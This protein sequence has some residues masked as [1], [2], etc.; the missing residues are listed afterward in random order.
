MSVVG[1]DLGN[2]NAVVAVARNRGV[3]VI[4]N[5]VSNRMTPSLVSFGPKSRYLGEAAK[6]QE[7]SNFRNTVASLKRLLGRSLAEV[8]EAERRH[9][10]CELT[11]K[12]SEVAVR[13]EYRGAECVFSATELLA[14]FLGKLKDITQAEVKNAAMD[15][16]VAVPVWYG[17]RQRRAMQDAL[18][19][20]QVRCVRLMN[21]TTA[22]ALAWGMP[23]TDLPEDAPRH[24]CFIDMG[25]ASY[26]ATVVAFRKGHLEV[27]GVGFDASFGGR[28]FDDALAE[29]CCTELLAT[30][31]LDIRANRKA[32]FRLRAGCERAKKV[33]SANAV[34]TLQVENIMNDVDVSVELQRATFET[35]CAPLLERVHAPIVRA[36]EMAK[37]GAHE[38]DVVELVGGTTR[39][40]ALKTR[41]ALL[42]G[43]ELSTTTNQDE[44]IARGCALQCA[45]QS[46]VFKVREFSVQDITVQGVKFTWDAAPAAPEDTEYAVFPAPHHTPS[47]KML[48]F[49]RALPFAVSAVDA[50]SGALLGVYAVQAPGE[51]YDLATMTVKVKTRVTPSGVFGVEGA[52]V[53]DDTDAARKLSCAVVATNGSL[54]K[55]E[56]L[57]KCDAEAAMASTDKLI[58]DTADSKNALEEYIYDMRAR[59]DGGSYERFASEPERTALARKL[60]AAEDWLYAEGEEATKSVYNAKLAELRA[61][62]DPI[63]ARARE[64]DALPPA[65]DVFRAAAQEYCVL[66]QSAAEQHSHIDAA[67]RA[68]VMAECAAKLQW[69]EKKLAEQAQ[70]PAHQTPVV[71]AAQL[72]EEKNRLIAF[73]FPI[74]NKPR[75]KAKSFEEKPAEP[76]KTGDANEDADKDA[77]G[78]AEEY[79]LT[80]EEPE[81]AK[82]PMLD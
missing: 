12:E 48:S 60:L 80:D 59:V 79:L 54:P 62:G 13:V 9:L 17:D 10:N 81:A 8:S 34:T 23:K 22:A 67:D 18:E 51:P 37:M 44:A 39:I 21:E 76:S 65:A 25:H 42:F 41:L 61:I 27:K 43:K 31:R 24:V 69:L 36:L 47:T 26:S 52:S 49:K 6:S 82:D 2:L 70:R 66:A 20:A 58:A 30:R 35:V 7:T 11:E 32:M 68:K 33:L 50:A 73:C 53:V 75:P 77:D 14:M 45:L 55:K 5:E 29:H 74:M 71:T 46:P 63:A 16:V 15:V 38:I 64:H 19:I 1:I 72:V 28:D 57:A 3:D 40:P 4:C 78:D 56:L